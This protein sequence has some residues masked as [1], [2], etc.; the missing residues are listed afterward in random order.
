MGDVCRSACH[1]FSGPELVGVMCVLTLVLAC[2]HV[3]TSG[4]SKNIAPTML[5]Q[6]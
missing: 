5:D 3:G 6:F 2:E 4:V 1:H